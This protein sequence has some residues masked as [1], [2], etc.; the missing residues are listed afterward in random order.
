MD[1]KAVFNSEKGIHF[2]VTLPNG[3]AYRFKGVNSKLFYF[4]TENDKAFN[5]NSK[6]INKNIKP[7]TPVTEYSAL[8]SVSKIKKT[9]Q[10]K[11]LRTQI[12]QETCKR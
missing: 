7:K 12:M 5:V 2:D 4:D 6:A 9:T 1:I 11:I 10:F 8:Q 3:V